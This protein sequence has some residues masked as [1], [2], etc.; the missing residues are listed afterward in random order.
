MRHRRLVIVAILFALAATTRARNA[1]RTPVF[2]SSTELVLINV[3]VRDKSGNVVRGLTQADF[4]ITEDNRPQTIATFDF[5]ELD[6]PDATAPASTP[7]PVLPQRPAAR[8]VDA[9]PGVLPASQ[10]DMHGR[11]LLV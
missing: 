5:E 9:G 1:Q 11:R 8:S 4:S 10:V 7:A 3:V 2:R 6:R